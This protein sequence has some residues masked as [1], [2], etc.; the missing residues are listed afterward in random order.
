MNLAENLAENLTDVIQ[1]TRT[2]A[3]ALAKLS[4]LV[5]ND[6]LE[7]IAIALE[8]NAEVILTANQEDVTAAIAAQL[9]S[10]LIARLKLDPNKLKSMVAGVRDVIRLDDPIG[11]R[12]IHRQL[13]AG[14]ILERFSC[15]LGVIGVIFEARPDAVTQ[16]A[17]LGIK[18]GNGVILK[19]GSE[20]VHSCE[21]IAKVMHDALEKLYRS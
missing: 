4:P 11:D 9:P 10:P 20:A 8:K 1:R 2:A 17:A 21:A 15:P 6:A 5:K 3:I 14:L 7:A 13:D 12:Q 16:I 19:G 18:S